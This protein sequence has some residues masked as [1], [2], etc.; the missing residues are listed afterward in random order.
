MHKDWYREL[1]KRIVKDTG[2]CDCDVVVYVEESLD[3][4]IGQQVKVTIQHEPGCNVDEEAVQ[5]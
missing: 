4:P 5:W 1:T 3:L 2:G